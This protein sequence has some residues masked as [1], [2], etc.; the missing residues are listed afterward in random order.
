MIID[1]AQT[2]VGMDK[3]PIGEDVQYMV[4][5][6]SGNTYVPLF[7]NDLPLMATI[8]GEALTLRKVCEDVLLIDAPDE[9]LTPEEKTKRSKLGMKILMSD[10]DQMDLDI[11]EIGLISGL[12]IKKKNTLVGGQAAEYLNVK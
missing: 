6:K 3:K 11:N 4:A 5:E 9:K 10:T 12:V 1:L 8:K 2:F 7:S